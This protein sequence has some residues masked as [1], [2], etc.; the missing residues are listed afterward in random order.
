MMKPHRHA[1]HPG[2]IER[3][4][5]ADGHLRH[6]V[7]LI[8]DGRRRAKIAVRLQPVEIDHRPGTGGEANPAEI[9]ALAELL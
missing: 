7:G 9:K 8:E 2:L 1:T 6:V 5:R 4:K 3:L